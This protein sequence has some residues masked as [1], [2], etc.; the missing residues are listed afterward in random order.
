MTIEVYLILIS[1]V[2]VALMISFRLFSANTGNSVTSGI[3][4]KTDRV[5]EKFILRFFKT[6]K[7]VGDSVSDFIKTLPHNILKFFH[8][9]LV[10]LSKKT[11]RWVDLIQGKNIPRS[12]G[13]VSLYLQKIDKEEK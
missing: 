3:L 12:K 1:F 11:K 6:S 7:R 8:L 10:K 9:M 13:A 2:L 5:L 4:F